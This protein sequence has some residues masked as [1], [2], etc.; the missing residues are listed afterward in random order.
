MPDRTITQE[1]EDWLAYL[2]TTLKLDPPTLRKMTTAFYCGAHAMGMLDAM[3]LKTCATPVEGV[4]RMNAMRRECREA[5][6]Q[7]GL[8]AA[9]RLTRRGIPLP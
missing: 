7:R 8:A 5:I 3:I 9:K 1:C 2:A 4:E 6:E